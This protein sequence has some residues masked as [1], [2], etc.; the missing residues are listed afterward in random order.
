[1][2][3]EKDVLRNMLRNVTNDILWNYLKIGLKEQISAI[4][5]YQ[6]LTNPHKSLWMC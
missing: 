3:L 6:I 4:L 1:M 2:T 5:P